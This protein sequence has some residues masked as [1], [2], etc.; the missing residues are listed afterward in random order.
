MK[1]ISKFMCKSSVLLRKYAP[2]I[3]I[4]L[5]IGSGIAGT[6]VACKATTK[7]ADIQ[8]EHIDE[9]NDIDVD[10]IDNAGKEKFHVYVRTGVKLTKT[11]LPAVVLVSSSIVCTLAGY[12]IIKARYAALSVAYSTLNTT[13]NEYRERVAAKY[14]AEEEY[15]LRYNI[16]DEVTEETV[17]G[18]NGKEKI[19]SKTS[20]SMGEPSLYAVWYDRQPFGE[21]TSAPEY[22]VHHLRSTQAFAND[23]LK[24]KGSIFLHEVYSMI[25]VED[26]L[27]PEQKKAAQVVGWVYDEEKNEL[28]GDGYISFGIGEL[29]GINV[30]RYLNKETPLLLDFNVDGNIWEL[31]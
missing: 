21:G 14:G 4:A 16:V 11:Y 10:D 1:N 13:F 6:I 28:D 30:Q 7:V 20:L 27:T 5:G 24:T 25:H 2:E 23:L 19:V 3:L 17:I 29:D 15:K 12:K 31:M 9:I 18:K 22:C 26:I 8:Q